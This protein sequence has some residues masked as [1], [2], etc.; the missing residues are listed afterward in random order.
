MHGLRA[1]VHRRGALLMPRVPRTRAIST[2]AHHA[3]RARADNAPPGDS[4]AAQTVRNAAAVLLAAAVFVSPA[5]LPIPYATEQAAYAAT[6]NAEVGKCVL[7]NC[8]KALAGCLADPTCVEN[9]I[10]LQSCNGKDNETE[11]QIKCGDKYQDSAIDTFNKCAVSEKKCVPQRVD[12]GVY[13]VPPDC[14]LD[15][16]FSLADFQG[17]W[18]I[19]AGLNTLF[20][21]FPCQEHYFASPPS[22]PKVVVGEINWRIPTDNGKDFIQRSTVQRFVQ[23]ENPA[24]L[25]NHGNEYLHYEDDWYILKSKPDEYVFIYYRG[26]N[27]AWKGYGGATVYTRERTLPEKY[28]PELREAA[29]AAG[30]D[31]NE[32]VL[33]DNSCPAKPA[34]VGPFEE[35]E[36]DLERVEEFASKEVDALERSVEPELKSFGRGFTVLEREVLEAEREVVREVADEERKV[37]EEVKKLYVEEQSFFDKLFGRRK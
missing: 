34:R 10:C 17:R 7:G 16:K 26:Q 19:T 32:F 13:P 29:E 21:T 36:E 31:W 8:Q 33:T 25:L 4:S 22:D 11:C 14:S 1:T 35:L 28:V 2:R 3:C 9:L 12:E 30:L 18:Y 5:S 15:T 6:D 27:D 20:D 24:I 23:Q 37:L